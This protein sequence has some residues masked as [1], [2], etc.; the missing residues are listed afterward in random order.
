MPGLDYKTVGPSTGVFTGRR[1]SFYDGSP[2]HELVSCIDCA[3]PADALFG[4]HGGQCLDAARVAIPK[5]ALGLIHA[6]ALKHLRF[7]SN[8]LRPAFDVAGVKP[9]SRGP[10]FASAVTRKWIEPDGSVPST[11]RA[12]KGHRVQTYTSLIHPSQTTR[13]AARSRDV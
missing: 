12:T 2:G 9:T 6:H 7:S 3:R 4:D 10:A 1:K 5:S 13:A 8:D 11:D